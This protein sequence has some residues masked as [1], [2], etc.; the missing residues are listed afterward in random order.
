M[1]EER[2]EA[3]G[4]TLPDTFRAVYCVSAGSKPRFAIQE[5]RLVLPTVPGDVL[6]KVAVSGLSSLDADVLTREYR[7]LNRR[8]SPF[9]V[10][11]D[12]SGTILACNPPSA[13]SIGDSVFGSLPFD[14]PGALAEYLIVPAA[15]CVYKPA[16]VPHINSGVSGYSLT[17]AAQALSGLSSEDRLLV[18]GATSSLGQATIGV[19]KAFIECEWVAGTSYEDGRAT[20][21]SFGAD[22][23]FNWRPGRA[24]K[25][26]E[27]RLN[28]K[29]PFGADHQTTRGSPSRHWATP[30]SYG[31]TRHEYQMV[32]DCVGDEKAYCLISES[33]NRK[34]LLPKDVLDRASRGFSLFSCRGPT[35][36]EGL[37]L[38]SPD[39]ELLERLSILMGLSRLVMQPDL[40][41]SPRHIIEALERLC[42]CERMDRGLVAVKW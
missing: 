22:E 23:V 24:A 36:A 13:F 34:S 18:L 21:E 14:S 39:P 31:R 38:P 41:I 11:Y 20:V 29:V 3:S 2:S 17:M 7:S 37:P 42:A 12:F 26:G 10:G 40:E 32:V 30:F 33:G 19:A 16:Q 15:L 28:L 27:N 25:V 35:L 6:V 8:S 1:A 9:R 4:V 5:E